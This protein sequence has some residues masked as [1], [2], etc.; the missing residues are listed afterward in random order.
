MLTGRQIKNLLLMKDITQIELA[1]YCG[2]ERPYI[3]MLIN[4]KQPFT[5][6]LYKKAIE[7][8]NS[9]KDFKEEFKMKIHEEKQK[10]KVRK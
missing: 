4:E 8:I 9:S 1:K 6:E 10:E 7:Y 3:S 5:E 2:V